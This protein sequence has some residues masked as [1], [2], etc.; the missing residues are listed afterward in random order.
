MKAEQ[1]E[2][3]RG[4]GEIRLFPEVP[5]DLWH[6]EHLISPGDLVFATTLRT[7]DTPQ[8]KLRPEKAEKRPVRIGIR[9]EK[10]SFHPYTNRLRIG[11]KIEHGPDMGAHH[12]F[13]I[14]AG[15]EISVI[16]QWSRLDRERLERAERS[17]TFGA[18]HILTLEEGE[19]QIFRL[20]QFGPEW[21]ETITIGSGKGAGTEGKKVL[22][23]TILSRLALITGH[24]VLAGPGFVKD[25]FIRFLKEKTPDL[26]DR[27]LVV[28]T[29]GTGRGGVQEV[30]G[31]GVLEQLVGDLQLQRE[32]RVME[33]FLTRISKGEPI[34]YG[35]RE[36]EEAVACGA[37]DQ[38]MVADSMLHDPQVTTI[39]EQA[40][41]IRAQIRI[42]STSFEPGMQLESLGGIAALLRYHLSRTT[43]QDIR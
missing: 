39:L 26:R 42:L 2:L 7:A 34:A 9:V 5:D 37:A 40:E 35:V 13:N 18:I 6:L 29:R 21:V 27:V 22:F 17:T 43:I 31:Q 28:E 15:T 38:I 4:Y 12:T 11:G 23:E 19:G 32:V 36:V 10:V 25:D 8:D 20:R 33:E 16:K 1:G 14:D 24:I 41:K 30:I 3:K